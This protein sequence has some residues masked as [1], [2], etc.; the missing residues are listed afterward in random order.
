MDWIQS[1]DQELP[2]TTMGAA[3]KIK[4]KQ[5]NQPLRAGPFFYL[6]LHIINQR[7]F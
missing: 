5:T 1:L 4:I 3:M 7:E 2:N 6:D